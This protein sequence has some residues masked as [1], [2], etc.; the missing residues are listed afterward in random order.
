MGIGLIFVIVFVYIV[1]QFILRDTRKKEGRNRKR[2]RNNDGYDSSFIGA[3]G[4]DMY[5]D[6]GSSAKHNGSGDSH[7]HNHHDHSPSPTHSS[8]Y[9]SGGNWGGDSGGGDSGGGDG[10]GGGGD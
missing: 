4:M 6:S 3:S 10:G 7:H 9:D 2:Y 8:S 1:V 5:S